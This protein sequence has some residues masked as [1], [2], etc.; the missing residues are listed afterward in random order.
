M[1]S[2]SSVLEKGRSRIF[3][4]GANNIGRTRMNL[5]RQFEQTRGFA[6]GAD[7]VKHLLVAS[8]FNTAIY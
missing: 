7:Y 2:T 4:C 8:S 1:V 3:N 5:L 6:F